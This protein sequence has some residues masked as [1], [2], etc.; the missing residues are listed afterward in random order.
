[1]ENRQYYDGRDEAFIYD[2]ENGKK[3]KQEEMKHSE[4]KILERL[5]DLSKETVSVNAG[6]DLKKESVV[7]GELNKFKI[8]VDEIAGAIVGEEAEKEDIQKSHT[9]KSYDDRAKM[10][11]D[12]GAN[13]EFVVIHENEAGWVNQKGIMYGNIQKTLEEE[14]ISDEKNENFQALKG[15]MYHE[16]KEDGADKIP[17]KAK[18]NNNKLDKG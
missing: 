11:K 7:Q 16:G 8:D 15:F 14:K 13:S 10:W 2:E 3:R 4:G 1:M 12:L 5:S 6:A 17:K 18:D 9:G